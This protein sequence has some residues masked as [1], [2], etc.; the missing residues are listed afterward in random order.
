MAKL[1]K[2]LSEQTDLIIYAMT[3]QIFSLNKSF[4]FT[5]Q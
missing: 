2:T 5:I 3:M 4:S 1:L